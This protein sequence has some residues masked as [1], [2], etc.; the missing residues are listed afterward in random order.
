VQREEEGF[1][2]KE[3]KGMKRKERKSDLTTKRRRE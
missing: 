2:H 1:N 3:K